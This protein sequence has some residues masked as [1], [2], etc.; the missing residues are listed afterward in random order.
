[1]PKFSPRKSGK[2]KNGKQYLS[3]DANFPASKLKDAG[4]VQEDGSVLEYIAR[5][6]PRKIILEPKD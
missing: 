1:M 4:F 3:Y 2:A 6:E 5:V